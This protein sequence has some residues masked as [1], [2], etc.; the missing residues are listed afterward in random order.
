[1]SVPLLTVVMPTRDRADILER[2]LDAL[3]AQEGRREAMDLVCVDDGSVDGTPEVL[4]RRLPLLPFRARAIRGEGSGPARARNLGIAAATADL[5][6]FLGDDTFPEPSWLEAHLAAHA[7]DPGHIVLGDVRWHPECGDDPFLHFLA[8]RGVQFDYGDLSNPEDL[9][10]DKFFTS[11]LSLPRVPLAEER[12]DERFPYAA[13]EDTELGWRLARRGMRIRYEPR[14]VV[15]HLHRYD[16]RGFMGRMETVGRAAQVLSAVR[17][18]LAAKVRPRWPAVQ[19]V[20]GWMAAPLPGD[21]LPLSIRRLR[22][23]AMLGGAFCR[24]YA[25]GR[26]R[27]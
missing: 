27:G 5:V 8:P 14:A 25:A 15:H 3:A 23:R 19:R 9:G 24:G 16:L 13:F 1:V 7:R 2:T 22:W 26:P 18:E 10:Y 11:N 4:Q 12:F 20:A 21:L 17:P 6:A